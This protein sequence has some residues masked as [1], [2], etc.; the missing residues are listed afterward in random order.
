MRNFYSQKRNV[1]TFLIKGDPSVCIYV[2]SSVNCVAFDRFV[3]QNE[4]W[5]S[6]TW[7]PVLFVCRPLS[8][9]GMCGVVWL[10]NVIQII[11]SVF[12]QSMHN[13]YSGHN[14]VDTNLYGYIC[15]SLQIHTPGRGTA[16]KMSLQMPASFLQLFLS[17][18][19]VVPV[20][21]LV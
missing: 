21:W 6:Q 5:N 13:Q 16:E 14:S 10:L 7:L 8:V 12:V 3:S 15:S 4:R 1:F 9:K 11:F 2:S 20:K 18:F 17:Q 19:S